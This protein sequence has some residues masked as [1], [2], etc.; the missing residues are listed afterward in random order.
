MIFG[1]ARN[2]TDF[3]VIIPHTFDILPNPTRKDWQYRPFGRSLRLNVDVARRL[4]SS[5]SGNHGFYRSI[6]GAAGGALFWAERIGDA[7]LAPVVENGDVPG[8]GGGYGDDE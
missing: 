3:S 8:D 6:P 1:Q 2:A 5:E 7:E 4:R